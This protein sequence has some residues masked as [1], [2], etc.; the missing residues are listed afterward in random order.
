MCPARMARVESSI[1]AVLAFYEA[2]NRH[3][4]PGMVQLVSDDCHFNNPR[5]APDGTQYA[6]KDAIRKYW[7]DFFRDSPEAHIEIEEAF[8][9]GERCIIRWKCQWTGPAGD[10]EYIRGA[11]IFRV[12][13]SLIYE[14]CSYVKG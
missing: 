12:R 5:P 11:D 3:D 10:P 8:S 6:G 2:F 14:Q 13:D 7:Q 9:L 1:R 4:V